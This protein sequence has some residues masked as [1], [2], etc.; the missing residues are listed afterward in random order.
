MLLAESENAQGQTTGGEATIDKGRI[1][2]SLLYPIVL[3][4]DLDL[5]VSIQT[6]EGAKLINQMQGSMRETSHRDW[7]AV[8]AKP[9]QTVPPKK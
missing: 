1:W 2:C 7:K 4:S 5:I 9:E 8:T 3:R 6:R